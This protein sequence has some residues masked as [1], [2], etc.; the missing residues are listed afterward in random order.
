[1][2][3]SSCVVAAFIKATVLRWH[4]GGER[5]Q[6]LAQL[7]VG[8]L[9]LG[10]DRAESTSAISRPATSPVGNTLPRQRDLD[11]PQ[12]LERLILAELGEGEGAQRLDDGGLGLGAAEPS[13]R[14]AAR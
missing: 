11:D 1:V 3:C 2:S 7:A 8:E 14:L 13:Q 4:W 5:E 6:D 9:A 10:G 12:F